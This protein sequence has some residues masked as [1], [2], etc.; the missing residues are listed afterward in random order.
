MFGPA[1]LI[2]DTKMA[3]PR[4]LL[5]AALMLTATAAAQTTGPRALDAAGTARI[6]VA[7]GRAVLI[8]G[9]VDARTLRS[10]DSFDADGRAQLEVS[11]G[12]RVRVG[13]SGRMSVD[14]FGPASFEWSSSGTGVSMIFGEFS[15]VD[16]EARAGRHSMRLPADWN[17]DFGRSSFHLRGLAGG[18]TEVRHNAG[19]P[20]TFDWRGGGRTVALPPVSVFPGSSVRLD[21][22]RS[23]PTE[24]AQRTDQL[25]W[26]AGEDVAA[27]REMWPWREIAET[28]GQRAERELFDRQTR[29]PS[30][31]PGA[32]SRK[33]TGLRTFEADGTSRIRPMTTPNPATTDPGTSAQAPIAPAVRPRVEVVPE[34]NQGSPAAGTSNGATDVPAPSAS[35]RERARVTFDRAQWRGLERSALNGVGVVAAERGSGVEVRILGA[36]RTKVFVSGS[37]TGPR[38]CFTPFG[39]FLMHPGAVAV[40]EK[41][42]ALRMSF[43]TTESFDAPKGR[44]RFDDLP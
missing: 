14:V 24:T 42:G 26:E 27:S 15:W 31:T 16:V 29:T 36:G 25:S 3:Q 11:A 21:R 40:F 4:T 2:P 28:P 19:S 20:V 10:N 37:S 38:W 41:D 8:G 22:P 13:W 18:P 1:T 23:I 34:A 9:G 7:T 44:P 32:P 5:A 6:S 39:D 12:S 33:V 35:A 43:G 17:A 30:G